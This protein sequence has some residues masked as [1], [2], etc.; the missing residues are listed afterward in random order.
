[1]AISPGTYHVDLTLTDPT[2]RRL[3]VD[4]DLAV[5]HLDPPAPS[6]P[7][8]ITTPPHGTS[9]PSGQS[10]TL[11]VV[12]AGTPP[13]AYQW[14]KN[15]E[16]ILGATSASYTTGPLTATTSFH[17][18]VMNAVGTA[19]SAAAV[20]TVIPVTPTAGIGLT[21]LR[22][23]GLPPLYMAYTYG[24]CSGRIVDGKVRLLFTGD[25]VGVMAPVY[26]VEVSEA[27]VAT[28]IREWPD[29]YHD[30]RGTWVTGE[31]LFETAT[32]LHQWATER[33]LPHLHLAAARIR[34]LALKIPKGEWYWM[35]FATASTA[36]L[37]GGH[38]Y[39]PE[40]DLFYVTY[41]DSYNVAGR[42][43]WNCL[44][45]RLH[46]DGTTEAFGPFRLTC[47]DGEGTLRYGP[48]AA[49]NLRPHPTRGNNQLG[50]VLC[51]SLSSCSTD[52]ARSSRDNNHLV[53]QLGAHAN[54]T[55]R[56]CKTPTSLKPPIMLGSDC[57]V[58]TAI[59]P[60]SSC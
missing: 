34:R 9:V 56:T 24:D 21:Y 46:D 27:P 33:Q 7:P 55:V 49:V 10:V 35:D 38:Y 36:A 23:I 2:G 40:L 32:A 41:A 45:L 8:T 17:V 4:G 43:D 48:R 60:N 5:E 13:L 3:L 53:L 18:V 12:A 22:T 26:E 14:K 31:S 39:H 30:K 29:P 28:F 42:P 25:W 6:V 57:L 52:P 59:S 44:A 1:M 50:S 16:P 19:T 11:S 37:N 58:P 51:K 15:G 47:R 54:P 20:V